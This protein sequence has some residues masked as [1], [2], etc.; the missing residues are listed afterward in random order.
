M[1]WIVASRGGN[2][3]DFRAGNSIL[4]ST[5]FSRRACPPATQYHDQSSDGE[6]LRFG[7]KI[8]GIQTLSRVPF[9]KSCNDLCQTEMGNKHRNNEDNC[10]MTD[11]HGKP[12]YPFEACDHV[13]R[14][15]HFSSSSLNSTLSASR[16]VRVSLNWR[17]PIKANVGNG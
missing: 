5:T 10:E 3:A 13:S 9:G 15:S 1:P 4:R 11:R 8:G 16:L 17:G 6:R 12:S 14:F 2:V 7:R